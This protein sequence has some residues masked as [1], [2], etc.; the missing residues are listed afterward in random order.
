VVTE[1]PEVVAEQA[2]VVAKQPEVVTEQPE[3]VLLLLNHS[4]EWHRI[5]GFPKVDLGTMV[6][7]QA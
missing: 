1:E 2:K 5:P 3:A 7:S 6:T 4:V